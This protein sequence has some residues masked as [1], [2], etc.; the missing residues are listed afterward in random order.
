M[1][2]VKAIWVV[3]QNRPNSS[4]LAA[5]NPDIIL[6][7]YTQADNGLSATLTFQKGY[8]GISGSTREDCM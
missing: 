7:K 1:L 4:Y 2:M 3:G 6:A 8:A 5:Y